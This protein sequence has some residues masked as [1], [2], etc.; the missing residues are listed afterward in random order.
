[1]WGGPL[2]CECQGSGAQRPGPGGGKPARCGGSAQA[3]PRP[4]FGA[5][6]PLL[7]ARGGRRAPSCERDAA[8]R[9]ASAECSRSGMCCAAKVAVSAPW[10]PS[11]TPM[12]ATRPG[13]AAPRTARAAPLRWRGEGARP[14]AGG[15]RGPRLGGGR[16]AGARRALVSGRDSFDACARQFF[17]HIH[18]PSHTHP[19]RHAQTIHMHTHLEADT[20]SN[21]AIKWASSNKSLRPCPAPTYTQQQTTA[22]TNTHN[23]V[24]TYIQTRR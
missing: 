14:W 6:P 11:N 4:S 8:M 13:A 21:V 19:L 9:P 10:W 17:T 24:H 23:P 20:G 2:V 3:P 7:H 18:P 12:L 5:A 16:S 22:R 15:V 1:M